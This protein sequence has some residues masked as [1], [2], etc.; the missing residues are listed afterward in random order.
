LIYLRGI[1]IWLVIIFAESFHGAARRFLLEPYVG[2]FRAR[3][4]SV[5]TGCLIIF[6]ISYLFIRWIRAASIGQLIGVGI[7]WVILTVGF[8]IVLGRL[9]LGFAWERILSDYNLREGGLMIFGLLFLIL[10]PY[11]A[12]KARRLI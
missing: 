7:F 3:Q 11:F 10:S 2:D 8:E 12:A 1:A 6:T 5:F 9:V 4:I